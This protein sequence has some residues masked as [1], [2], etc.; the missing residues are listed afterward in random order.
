[1]TKRSSPSRAL[2]VGDA[3]RHHVQ[4]V[5]AQRAGVGERLAD[6]GQLGVEHVAPA[7]LHVVRLAEL[8]H[9]G[10]RPALPGGGGVGGDR[11]GVAL[12]HRDA[13]A[14]TGEHEAGGE[15][16]QATAEDDRVGHHPRTTPAGA[17]FIPRS[18]GASSQSGA[19]G[20]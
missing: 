3:R 14:V 9:A 16:A 2:A 18:S 19:R 1:M 17:A 15:P 11:G 10:A 4:R 20:S 8:G 5:E 12:E 13:V 7:R 6:V